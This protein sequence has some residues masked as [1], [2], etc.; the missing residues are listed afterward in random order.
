MRDGSILNVPTLYFD[1]SGNTGANHLDQTQ[2]IYSLASLSLEPA[3]GEDLINRH[4]GRLLAG[5]IKDLKYSRLS[6]TKVGRI[7]V[8]DFL[9][10]ISL[11]PAMHKSYLVIKKFALVAKYVDWLI[12]PAVYA[13]GL[14]LYEDGAIAAKGLAN[15]LW[16]TAPHAYPVDEWEAVLADFQNWSTGNTV[17]TEKLR[18]RIL[19][20]TCESGWEMADKTLKL[21]FW[22]SHPIEVPAGPDY[23]MDVS[24][25]AAYCIV[26]AWMDDGAT[27]IEIVHDRSKVME[28]QVSRWSELADPAL[29]E[30]FFRTIP[31]EWPPLSVTAVRFGDQ[32]AD[33][34]LQLADIL[35]GANRDA[36]NHMLGF[37]T[38]SFAQT[39]R[40]E[41]GLPIPS[42]R[43]ICPDIDLFGDES[44]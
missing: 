24:F 19:S 42:G 9:R 44:H 4:F 12:E 20:L 36:A 39:L 32:Y 29:N 5:G 17:T 14:D 43:A 13:D 38:D 35:A 28:A 7:A 16:F 30:R 18:E 26:R 37:S 23:K 40:T 2:R 6:G 10:E 34:P 25:S 22:S 31:G 21:P 3:H 27:D 41:L 1:E 11:E 33:P 8:L 15:L